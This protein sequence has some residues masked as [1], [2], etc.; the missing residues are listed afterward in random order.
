[1]TG[2]S[3]LVVVTT[4]WYN[5][6]S[7]KRYLLAERTLQAAADLDITVVVVDGSPDAAVG[8]NFASIGRRII[9][10][11][12]LADV[13]ST[14]GSGLRQGIEHAVNICAP[15]GVISC[16]E[17]EKTDM[18]RYQ[19]SIAASLTTLSRTAAGCAVMVPQRSSSA[20]H[21]YP[22][23]QRLSEQFG[24]A[25]VNA[26]IGKGSHVR[27]D[28]DWFFGPFAF[29][30]ELAPFWLQRTDA[31][32]WDA[33]LLPILDVALS[34]ARPPVGV[35]PVDYTHPAEQREQEEGSPDFI[36]KRLEQLHFLLPLMRRR[37]AQTQ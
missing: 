14:K 20:W 10:K 8:Q 3:P 29:T 9:V 27:D 23:E 6:T 31:M 36:M 30:V 15:G 17:P 34:P 32:L 4:T 1:M 24:N 22:A 13:A 16:M 7:D 21:S 5:S 12:Q 2:T 19:T 28:I 33:Q 35:F 25:A 18:I 37:I 26:F 11:R